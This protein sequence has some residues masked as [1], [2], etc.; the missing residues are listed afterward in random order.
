[1]ALGPADLV[2]AIVTGLSRRAAADDAEQAVYSLDARDEVALHP[3]IYEAL[4]SWGLGVWPEERYPADRHVRKKPEAKRCD[5]VLT[6]ETRPLLTPEVANTL[7]APPDAVPLESAYWLEIKTVAQH[8]PEG[9]FRRYARELLQ[10]VSSDLRKLASDPGISHA[11]LLLV[12]F[13]SDAE[14][15]EH[16]L[17]SWESRV[18][19]KGLPV[20]SPHKRGFALRDRL[21]NAHATVALFPVRR[22]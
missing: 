15:A 9:P 14:T 21:G 20:A 19:K 13:T 11:G 10:P 2:D 5:V 8:T 22:L 18:Y 6:P 16:D 17:Q 3:V 1:M 7:F 12:L 4:R